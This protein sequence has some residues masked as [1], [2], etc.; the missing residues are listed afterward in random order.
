M[1]APKKEINEIQ[2]RAFL[3]LKPSL[4]DTAAFFDCDTRTIER[5]IKSN[6]EV[7]FAE[8]RDQNMVHTRHRLVQ[9]AIQEALREKC[10]TAMLIFCLKNLCGWKDKIEHSAEELQ[11]ILFAYDPNRKLNP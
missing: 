1:G 7:T 6:F 9:K 10:N 4:D 3:R 8:F 2:L 11:P 5:F